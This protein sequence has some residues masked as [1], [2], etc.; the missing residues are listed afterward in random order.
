MMRKKQYNDKRGF[1]NRSVVDQYN[2]RKM[3]F[4]QQGYH[5]NNHNQRGNKTRNISNNIH[6]EEVAHEEPQLQQFFGAPQQMFTYEQQQIKQNMKNA[7][8]FQNEK[9]NSFIEY[10][11]NAMRQSTQPDIDERHERQNEMNFYHQG[12]QNNQPRRNQNNNRSRQPLVDMSHHQPMQTQAAEIQHFQPVYH[13][14]AQQYA[15]VKTPGQK[16]K[17]GQ[18]TTSDQHK[19]VNLL[20]QHNNQVQVIGQQ[21]HQS[22]NKNRFMSTVAEGI[23][24]EN[25]DN[26]IRQ[27]KVKKNNQSH[28]IQNPR[29]H[30]SSDLQLVFDDNNQGLQAPAQQPSC[31]QNFQEMID[32]IKNL[33]DQRLKVIFPQVCLHLFSNQIF[34]QVS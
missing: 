11:Y 31:I 34:T 23:K 10:N 26:V 22:K 27:K 32:L 15:Q 13:L 5:L 33:I 18:N 16:R 28:L 7:K 9:P 17:T 30:Q 24:M 4:D 6:H 2:S 21:R 14:N 12:G 29:T 25:N 8:N 3:T 1:N 19:K 20:N